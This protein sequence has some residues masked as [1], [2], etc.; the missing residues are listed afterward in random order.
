[1]TIRD[2][3]TSHLIVYLN[4]TELTTVRSIPILWNSL[5]VIIARRNALSITHPTQFQIIYL[6][7]PLTD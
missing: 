7:Y 3:T 4:S 1:M 5:K 2:D 6:I